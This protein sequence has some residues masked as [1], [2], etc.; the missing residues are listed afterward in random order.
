MVEVIRAFFWHQKFVPKGFSALASGLY[1]CI[2]SL[3]MCLKSDLE[4]IILK[5]ATYGQRKRPFCC[6]KIFVPHQGC[7]PLSRAI[8][9]WKKKKNINHSK[10]SD[11]K[12]IFFLNWQQM[13]KVIRN[14]CWHQNFVLKGLS[15]SALGLYTC[16]KSFKMF[17]KSYFKE[18]LKLVTNGQSD[19][20]FLLTSTF[21]P[22]GLSA[23]ALG[24]YTCIKA[25]K[26]IPGP[27]V[28]WAFTGPLVLW[29]LWPKQRLP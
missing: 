22:K 18:V 23:P 17:L 28:R 15:V 8:Y 29:F 21:V 9:M 27:G 16:I 3:K 24:V 2:K 6:H 1:A 10:I 4:E 11:F 20:G 25:L 7:L 13:G 26:Y 14:F 5:L 12:V 19:K